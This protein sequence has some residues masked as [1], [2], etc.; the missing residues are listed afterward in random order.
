MIK[1]LQKKFILI[2]MVSVIL[3]LTSIMAAIN[4]FNYRDIMKASDAKL[5]LISMY[6]G[7]LGNEN[8]D[9]SS[10][11][12]QSPSTPPELSNEFKKT[13]GFNAETPFNTRYF[14]VTL[15]ADGEITNVNL[16]H[17]AAVSSSEAT[18]VSKNLFED[19]QTS[20][21]YGDYKYITTAVTNSDGTEG[22]MYIF[23]DCSN[24]LNNFRSFLYASIGVSVL[25]TALVFLLVLLLSRQ[26]VRPVA[27]SYEKQ[28]RFITDASHEL[29]TPLAI[30][31]ANTEV[32]EL[33]SGESEWTKSTKRQI[34]RLSSLTEK[35]VFLSRMDEEGSHLQITE[36]SLSDVISD[37][38]DSFAG[39]AES[40]GKSLTQTIQ[41][42]IL[43]HGDQAMMQ[44]MTSLLVDNAMKYSNDGGQIAISLEKN[45]RNI[46]LK[47]YNTVEP[48]SLKVGNLDMLFERFYRNDA[49]R[50]SK[51]GGHG[52]GLSVVQAI[53]LA[54]R[55]KIHAESKDGNSILFTAVL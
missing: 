41:P 18:S 43:F 46:V 3:V 6:D 10:N 23:L 4:I 44:Q 19:S 37:T 38:V 2:T 26:A 36:F 39:V 49:S 17:I 31:D 45:G 8:F 22:T 28:K 32:I 9:P 16:G 21:F 14:T 34:S 12:E 29:K 27:E 48:G 40:K 33:E 35:L 51:T 47:V 20:G 42:G 53:V 7:N 15:D 11:T 13:N 54:H 1:S 50:N 55:G 5:T 24:D 25:G 30:I 52:I